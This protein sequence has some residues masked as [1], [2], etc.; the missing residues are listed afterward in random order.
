MALALV[1]C[2]AEEEENEES[3][4]EE[5][6]EQTEEVVETEETTEH[7]YNVSESTYVPQ[8]YVFMSDTIVMADVAATLGNFFG[9]TFS[10]VGASGQTMSAPTAMAIG[11]DPENPDAPFL[12]KAGVQ[13]P[14]A[15][16]VPEGMQIEEMYGGDVLMVTHIGPYD[17]V[18]K[19]YAALWTAMEEKGYTQAGDPW[20]MYMNDPMEVGMDKAQTDV[21]LP[22]QK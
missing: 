13:I 11:Y 1:A 15:I 5:A 8:Q 21:Y 16:E 7:E 22:I 9:A 2:G 18:E 3:T 14:K 19:A 12:C 4:S 17:Q 6:G 20:E 10:H